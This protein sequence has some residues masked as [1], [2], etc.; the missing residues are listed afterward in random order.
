M[1]DDVIKGHDAITHP[2]MIMGNVQ[3]HEFAYP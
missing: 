2:Q 3:P 1:A